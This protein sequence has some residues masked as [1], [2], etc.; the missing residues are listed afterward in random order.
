MTADSFP[1]P[2]VDKPF[3]K[4]GYAL[5]GAAYAVHDEIGGGMAEEIYQESFERELTL[6]RI[7]FVAKQEL[8]MF[9]KGYE[10]RKRY[11]PDLY[12]FESIVIELKA[13]SELTS[14]HYAQLM[15]YMRISRKPVGYLINFGPLE[16]TE[17]KRFVIREFLER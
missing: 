6:R 10:L 4:E 5:I 8:A 3:S 7:S 11:I 16:K 12:A 14:E 1:S 15:N 13:V 2:D 9:Y 17:W